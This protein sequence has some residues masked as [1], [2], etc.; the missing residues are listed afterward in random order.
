MTRI[1]RI[2]RD[3]A[4]CYRDVR[5]RALQDAPSAFATTLAEALE[6]SDD[7]WIRRT[8]DAAAGPDSTLYL[9]W[10]PDGECTGMVAAIRNVVEPS[11]A[12]L[13]SMWVAP[14]ARGS[15]AGRGLVRHVIEWASESGY[16]RVELWVTRGNESAQRLYRGLGFV[17]TGDVKPL[18]S[19]PCKDESR[20]R[21]DLG[22]QT[23]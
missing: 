7:V 18:P 4:G 20:M 16:R 21:L 11:T 3:E 6:F 2:R 23:S 19:D 12:D 22:A 1:R 8:R 10:D 17:E 13:I 14:N 5:L 15:G 9:A